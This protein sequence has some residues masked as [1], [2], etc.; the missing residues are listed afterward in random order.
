[1]SDPGLNAVE[2]QIRQAQARGAFDD[3]PG[4]GKPLNLGRPDDPDWW[5][6]NLVER[7]RLDM[8]AVLPSAIQLRKEAD[9]FPDALAD[10]AREE[11]V[12]EVLDDYNRRVRRDRIRPAP[13]GMPRV[14]A[15]T[16]DVDGLIARWADLRAAGA[17]DREIPGDTTP[18]KRRWWWRRRSSHP[19]QPSH[20]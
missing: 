20:G 12:R 4:A 2:Q 11:T 6:K 18:V 17:V 3:L 7:E 5:V 14:I 8:S 13:A 16:V 10:I 9:G 15:P 19:Y 1:M